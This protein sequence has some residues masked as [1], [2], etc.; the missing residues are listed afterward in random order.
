[1]DEP[2][3]CHT[4]KSERERQILYINQHIYVGPRKMVQMMYLQSRNRVTDVKNTL[5]VTMGWV[6]GRDELGDWD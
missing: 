3:D 2:G 4:V 1:M 6:V 5:T